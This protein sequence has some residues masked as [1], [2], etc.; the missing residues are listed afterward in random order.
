[1]VLARSRA[2]GRREAAG[3][4]GTGAALASGGH[5]RSST[6]PYPLAAVQHAIVVTSGKGVRT[7]DVGGSASTEQ[8]TAAI[9]ENLLV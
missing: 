1:V 9:I 2:P 4:R 5:G 8:V 3:H 7:R 6:G